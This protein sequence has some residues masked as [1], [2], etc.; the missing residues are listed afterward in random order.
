MTRIIKASRLIKNADLAKKAINRFSLSAVKYQ[1]LQ[2]VSSFDI[3][4]ELRKRQR[5]INKAKKT[6]GK[7]KKIADKANK[8]TDYLKKGAYAKISPAFGRIMGFSLQLIS[9]GLS[10]A[11][12]LLIKELNEIN[13]RQF[14]VLGKSQNNLIRVLQIINNKAKSNTKKINSLNQDADF[15]SSQIINNRKKTVENLELIKLLNSTIQTSVTSFSKQIKKTNDYINANLRNLQ[16]QIKSS[17]SP[18]Q[19]LSDVRSKRNAADIASLKSKDRSLQQQVNRIESISSALESRFNQS[20]ANINQSIRNINQSITNANQSIVNLSTRV[21]TEFNTRIRELQKQFDEKLKRNVEAEVKKQQR[22]QQQEM[23]ELGRSLQKVQKVSETLKNNKA[24]N[25]RIDGFEIALPGKILKISRD[26]MEA[27]LKEFER[28]LKIPDSNFPNFRGLIGQL[29]K[30]I[31][32]LEKD[33]QKQ[34]DVDKIGNQKLDK[35]IGLLALVP[36]RSAQ[37]TTRQLAP[38]I[39]D[40]TA[41]GV[42]KTT[43][44]GG[45]MSKS[46]KNTAD[47][48]NKNTNQWGKNLFDKINAGANA[49]QLALLKVIDKKLGKQIVGGI[50]GGIVKNLERINKFAEWLRIDRVLNILTWVNT[51]HNAYMLSS[52]ITNTLF[53]AIDNVANIF[54]KDINGVNIDSKS[55]VSSY[56]DNM[57]KAVFGVKEW[58]NITTTI[59]KYNRIYQTGA[60]IIN[61]V[62]SIVDSTRNVTEYIAENT[63]KIGNA[64]MRYGAIAANAFPKLP[65][66]VNAQSI[67]VQRLNNLE[68]AA[69]GIEMVT[70]EVLQ[71]TE[72]VNQIK[73]QTEE[74][75]KSVEDLEPKVRKDNK[76]VKERD[77]KE[78]LESQ[79]P[80]IPET[81][82]RSA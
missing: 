55:A 12:F 73:K 57:A 47:T 53:G 59:K 40:L 29:Q 30:Q 82:E 65:E 5:E 6:V 42:C 78:E 80:F 26:Y 3:Y 38:K 52:S 74:F 71:I 9:L 77:D 48:I 46:L 15:L 10:V 32:L 45:C 25:S 56:F 23:K 28:N 31:N 51:T 44:S 81:A 7:V 24:D 64:L 41:A 66:Q 35:L 22:Q 14:D 75:N 17:N 20:I 61:S 21:R 19:K 58:K 4:N 33:F 60:N 18:E 27:R 76:P 70:S 67:W 8:I 34:K 72:N 63:G 50:S 1:K 37:E 49:A 39:P 68:E 11:N 13:I 2:K 43:R 16:K 69:S 79:S 36:A 62:R 54:F